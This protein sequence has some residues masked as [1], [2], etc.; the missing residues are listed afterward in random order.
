MSTFDLLDM[1]NWIDRIEGALARL[2]WRD[3]GH[4][5]RVPHDCG[6]TGQELEDILRGYGVDIAGRR[7]TSKHLIF[8][9]KQRQARW[10]EHV[11]LRA[12]VTP[13]SRQVDASNAGAYQRHGGAMPRPWSENAQHPR[14]HR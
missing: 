5:M 3:A 12:G 13:D 6:H 14:R 9:V 11:L 4:Q 10:A 8:F 7:V 1:F 2:V